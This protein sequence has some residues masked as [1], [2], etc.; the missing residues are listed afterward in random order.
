MASDLESQMVSVERVH[1]YAAMPTEGPAHLPD[2]DPPIS[3][4]SRGAITFDRVCMR[5][6]DGLPFV[7]KDCSFRIPSHA[8]VGIVGRTGS[9]KSTLLAA[10]LRLVELSSGSICLDNVDLA[11]I[12]LHALRSRVCVIPQDPVLF[13]GDVRL[14]LDPFNQYDSL[15][16]GEALRSVGLVNIGLSD[17]VEDG[18]ANLSVGQRQMLCIARA[19]LLDS[20]VILM[21]EA[22]SNI[23]V[24]EDA[25]IQAAIRTNFKNATC[26]TIAH[27]LGTITDSD[28]VLVMDDGAVAEFDSPQALLAKSDSIFADLVRN[29]RDEG[30]ERAEGGSGGERVESGR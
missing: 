2:R 16:I 27:R 23:S 29:W 17:I 30:G 10:L 15:A 22:T 7:L 1:E 14:N 8:K 26:L 3:W 21:D 24:L 12:G 25:V 11:H 18:G 19:L 28:L 13:S 6:R 20:R 5:Y 9:G 4:P